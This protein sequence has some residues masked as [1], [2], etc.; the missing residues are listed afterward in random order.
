[1]WDRAVTPHRPFDGVIFTAAARYRIDP[2]ERAVLTTLH[3]VGWCE[4]NDAGLRR[5]MSASSNGGLVFV[6]GGSPE[7]AAGVI[8]FRETSANKTVPCVQ[9]L[10]EH[11]ARGRR[12]RE[13]FR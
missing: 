4:V 1:V 3:R 10:V 13:V 2:F 12:H 8:A 9:Q 5:V 7:S 6:D 11:P